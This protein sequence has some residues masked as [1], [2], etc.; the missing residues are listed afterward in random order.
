MN[1]NQK[2]EI[3]VCVRCRLAGDPPDEPRVGL[4]FFEAIE[5]EAFRLDTSF[6][7]RPIECMSACKRSCAVALQS[8]GKTTYLFGDL[9]PDTESA[10]QVVICAQPYQND[11]DGAM[12]RV[13]RPDRLREGILERLPKPSFAAN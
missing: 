1:Q 9:V 8:P 12:P 7:V 10:R 6:A 11:P 13:D 5:E 2:I 4:A 3:L